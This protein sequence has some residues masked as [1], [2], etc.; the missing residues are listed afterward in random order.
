MAFTDLTEWCKDLMDDLAADAT[1]S[2][3]ERYRDLFVTSS[4]YEYM[5]W[6]AAWRQEEWPV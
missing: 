3:R 1:A 2:D 4:R 6:D 5:F